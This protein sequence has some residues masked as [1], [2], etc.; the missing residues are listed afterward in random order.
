M[1]LREVGEDAAG[2][3]DPRR[4]A[5]LERVRGDLHR[6]GLVAAVEHAPEGGLEVDRLGRRPFD[7]LLHAPHDALDRA[8]Q[9]A[10]DPGR[11]EQV[12]DEERRGGLAVRPGDADDGEL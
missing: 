11:V 3:A 12:P 4:P 2:E 10:L 1:V 7:L 8:E 5:E 9:A 6:A